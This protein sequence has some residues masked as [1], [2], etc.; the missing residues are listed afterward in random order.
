MQLIQNPK[1]FDVLLCGNMFG[2]IFSD[3][4]ASVCGSI[5]MLPSASLNA[6]GFRAVRTGRRLGARHRGQGHRQPDR[7]DSLGG[8]AAATFA[9]TRGSGPGG[10]VGRR[11][12]AGRRAS[13][14]RY[15]GKA[16]KAVGTAAMGNAIAKPEKTEHITK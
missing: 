7:A 5:G 9:E 13:H 11:A 14:P 12:G 6:E 1:R 10:R 4:L 16:D 8:D 2:D 15:C 3:E